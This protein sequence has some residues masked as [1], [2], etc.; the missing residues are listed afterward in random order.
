M[1]TTD[2]NITDQYRPTGCLTGGR[3]VIDTRGYIQ[4]IEKVKIGNRLICTSGTPATV[5]GIISI[6]TDQA[7]QITPQHGNTYVVNDSHRLALLNKNT[8]EIAVVTPSSWM[9]IRS[10]KKNQW[11]L[12]KYAVKEFE[13]PPKHLQVD[14]YTLGNEHYGMF[15]STQGEDYDPDDIVVGSTTLPS[16]FPYRTGTIKDRLEFLAGVMDA[17]GIRTATGYFFDTWYPHLAEAIVQ[18]CWSVGI[19]A[20]SPKSPSGFSHILITDTAVAIPSRKYQTRYDWSAVESSIPIYHSWTEFLVEKIYT[21]PI[22]FYGVCTD[23][24]E[25]LLL[26][27]DYT[28]I[29]RCESVQ[30]LR[31]GHSA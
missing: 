29:D 4:P 7:Y 31:H 5:T 18:L 30:A 16:L 9:E 6:E 2:S 27:D 20:E 24:S 1:S 11:G 25:G 23:A 22:K 12:F 8:G 21:S 17:G 26:A 15:K 19:K 3:G 13:N 10:P 14:P 28:C